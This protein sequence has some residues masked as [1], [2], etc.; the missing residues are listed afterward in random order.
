MELGHMPYK[1]G[2]SYEDYVGAHGLERLGAKKWRK[3]VYE[4]IEQFK[5]AFEVDYVVLGGGNAER[6]K[7]I[8][9]DVC[10]GDNSNAMAGGQLLWQQSDGPLVP[11]SESRPRRPRAAGRK[12]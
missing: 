11:S 8:P 5:T 6:L 3:V 2:R 9:K 4:V 12:K 1:H 10:L 7:A